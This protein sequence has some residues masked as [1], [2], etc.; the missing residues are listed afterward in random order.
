MGVLLV[1]SGLVACNPNAGG[2]II[3]DDIPNDGTYQLAP[4][5]T[6]RDDCA[7]LPGNAA[8]WKGPMQN[9]GYTLRLNLGLDDVHLVGSLDETGPGFEMDG[10]VENVT[11]TVHGADC[12]LDT[13]Q[14]HL[15]GSTDSHTAFHGEIQIAYAAANRNDCTCQL[16]ATYRAT[17]Q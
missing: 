8:R 9:S 12:L 16:W 6:L 11:E 3:N 17:K 5:E 13:L 4:D 1:A 7:L 10:T 15:Q 2:G 14:V